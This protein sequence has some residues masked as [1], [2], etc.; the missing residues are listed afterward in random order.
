MNVITGIR[1]PATRRGL[2][3]A[4]ALSAAV[5]MSGCTTLAGHDDNSSQQIGNA[6]RPAFADPRLA[7]QSNGVGT[8][9]PTAYTQKPDITLRPGDEHQCKPLVLKRG[10]R[11]ALR[12]PTNPDSGLS[13]QL[14]DRPDGLRLLSPPRALN[15]SASDH[16]DDSVI[17][18]WR[19]A[20]TAASKGQLRLLYHDAKHQDK[21][22][23]RVF[24]CDIITR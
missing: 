19:F 20:V 15:A 24:E 18:D 21:A 8:P 5:L 6:P 7:N 23:E 1:H 10:Q 16:T 14:D 2:K 3:G 4:L 11:V 17:F 12:L 13:W 9:D 22:P